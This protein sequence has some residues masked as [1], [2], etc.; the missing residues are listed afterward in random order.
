MRALIVFANPEPDSFNGRLRTVALE[1]LGELG[2]ETEI[3]DLYAQRFDP[4]EG[5]QHYPSRCQ[6]NRFN[7]QTEQEAAAA[8]SCISADVRAEIEKLNPPFSRAGSIACSSTARFIR[9]R[10]ATTRAAM[11]AGAR[12]CR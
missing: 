8:R 3:S 10:C 7:A 9:R 4:V 12:C 5:P 2:Y 1:T 11:P 6:P